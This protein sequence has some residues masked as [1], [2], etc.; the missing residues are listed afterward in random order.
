MH[1][2][3]NNKLEFP[4]ISGY[5]FEVT[6]TPKEK[7]YSEFD[8]TA[9]TP[10]SKGLDGIDE[11][12]ESPKRKEITPE[13]TPLFREFCDNASV[14]G[15]NHL[16]TERVKVKRWVW[17]IFVILALGFNLFHCSL[18]I[19]KYLGFPSEETQFVDQSWIEFPS[20]TICNINAMSRI[21]RKKMLED[22]STLLYKWHD[23]VNNRF[24]AL[25]SDLADGYSLEGSNL[26]DTLELLYNRVH[27]PTGYLENIGEEALEV[28]H[29][30]N[31]LVVDCT[32]GITKCHAV[33]FTAF[34]ESTYY[35]CYTFNGGNVSTSHNNLITR[36]TGP[37]EGLS[38][39][40]YL[41]SDNGNINEN[42]SYLTMS[43]L[44]NAA[45][46]RVMIHAPNTM[47]SPTDQGFDIPPGFSSSVGV[48]VSTRTRLGE[49]YAKCSKREIN[50]GTDYLYSDNICL[51]LCQQRYVMGNCNCISS[52]LPFDRSTDLYFCGHMDYNNNASFFENMA[53]ESRVLEEFVHNEDVRRE[54]GCHPPCNNYIYNYQTSQSYWP[55][56]YYQADFYDLY[57]L[58]DP[59]KENLK[60]YQ[61]LKHHNVPQLIEKGL[62]RKNFLRLNV[63][64]KDLT[65]VQH[66][67]KRS[68]AIENLFS[69]VGGTFG[70][71]A[72]MSI[73]TICEFSEL[74]FR[75]M[76][77][78]VSKFLSIFGPMSTR[79]VVEDSS[80][81]SHTPVRRT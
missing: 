33:N 22:N 17:T 41:E 8:F 81:N 74:F 26:L 47:P 63:Y 70:L 2:E 23:Y 6:T 56:E 36:T 62:I 58:S 64:L 14:H 60:A 4:P 39:I 69:D 45:G 54:C 57:I 48:S 32:F 66:I 78:L 11:K 52:L 53:C 46:A 20:V 27:L 24:E 55:L 40:M 16:R 73:L 65:I 18:L 76:A 59:N 75:V 15:V 77:I 10:R 72:G 3:S 71:W 42:G 37:Q 44:N 12:N 68:Y 61:N 28:G 7:R 79:A 30:L 31:D 25:V 13:I 21:T 1:S 67:E 5:D 50:I 38:I 43:K 9:T 80:S 34:F 29:K 51:K 19:D 35:N 49:P